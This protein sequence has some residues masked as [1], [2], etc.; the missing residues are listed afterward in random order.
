MNKPEIEP[1][2]G[3]EP[4]ELVIEDISIGDGDEA[5]PGGNVEVHYLGVTFDLSK[6]M[7]LGTANQLDGIPNALRDR[8]EIISLP[9]YSQEEK[10][11]IARRYLIPRQRLANGVDS[12]H[13]ELTDALIA[14]LDAEETR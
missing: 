13:G 5:A 2:M 9:G 12:S 7:F 11:E 14:A 3:P 8:M 6:V 4:T 10:L 1:T